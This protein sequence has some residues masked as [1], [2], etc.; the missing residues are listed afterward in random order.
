MNRRLFSAFLLCGLL[1]F[2]FPVCAAAETAPYF[3][4]SL[5][6]QAV[7]ENQLIKLEIN[8]NEMT[9]PAAGFRMMISYDDAQLSFVRTET[10]SQIKSGT[11]ET[12]SAGNPIYSVYVC[13]V[14]QNAAPSLSGN[15]ISF[16]F[17]VK[18]GAAAGKTKI[19]AQI[20]QICNYQAQKLNLD[21]DEDLTFSITEEGL[22]SGE[23]FLKSLVPVSGRLSPAFSPDIFTY[24]MEVPA[25]VSSVEFMAEAGS[26]GAVTINRRTLGKSGSQTSIIA[27][28]T[29]ADKKSS[30]QYV[31]LV[32]RVEEPQTGNSSGANSTGGVYLTKLVPLTGELSPSFSPAVFAYSMEVPENV[33]TVEFLTEAGNGGTAAV[34]RR[35]LGKAGSQTSIIVTATSADHQSKVDYVILVHRKAESAS[36]SAGQVDTR[37]Q[38]AQSGGSGNR[39]GE[40]EAESPNTN[41]SPDGNHSVNSE[42]MQTAQPAARNIIIMGNQMPQYLLLMLLCANC[43]LIGLALSIW[44][45]RKKK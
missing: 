16:V 3:T 45:K 15:I 33:S 26:G 11:M 38:T 35:T 31:V 28:V 20:D 39:E 29:S 2:L 10:S 24:A 9:D 6:G 32:H 19:R 4:F 23:A 21:Y 1:I 7:S 37:G 13:N 40:S 43:I 42:S 34:N 30:V 27:T 5:S 41:F 36:V 44:L 12:N 14:D 22:P 17:K 25:N 8:A 18:D